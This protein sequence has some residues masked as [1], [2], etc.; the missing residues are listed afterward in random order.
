L[1]EILALS[2]VKDRRVRRRVRSGFASVRLA[3][4]AWAGERV[5][6]LREW[7]ATAAGTDTLVFTVFALVSFGVF[8]WGGAPILDSPTTIDPWLYTALFVN[9]GWT[10]STFAGTYYVARLPWVLPGYILH[11]VF[12]AVAAELIL[13]ALFFLAG[14]LFL[15][16]LVRAH[17]GRTPAF[18]ALAALWLSQQYHNA[19]SWDYVDGPSITYMLGSL[20]FLLTPRT[21]RRRVIYLA[22][23]GFFLAADMT[24]NIFNLVFMP[25]I[26]VSYV[27]LH[28]ARPL[29]RM[30]R[31]TLTD[32]GAAG[33]GA[34]ALILLCGLFSTVAGGPF[35]YFMP[36]FRAA[37][38]IHV[39]K[40]PGYGWLRDDLALLAPLLVLVGT[41]L[42]LVI[43][44]RSPRISAAA[45][46]F[47]LASMLALA[48]AA[49]TMA[50]LEFVHGWAVLEVPYYYDLLVPF[51]YVAV[52]SGVFL[53]LRGRPQ[54][55]LV[56]ALVLGLG[57][58]LL[59]LLLIEIPNAADRVGRAGD[60]PALTVTLAGLA[61][62][63]L[64]AVLRARGV[65]RHLLAL[66]AVAAFAF[67]PN[68]AADADLAVYGNSS[69]HPYE[70]DVFRIGMDL[71]SYL[72]SSGLQAAGRKPWFWYD[73]RSAP[74]LVG[75][76]SLYFYGYTFIGTKLPTIDSDFRFRMS[77]RRPTQLVLLCGEPDCEH[78]AKALVT[79]GIGARSHSLRLLRSGS[80]RIWVRV[81]DL[82]LPGTTTQGVAQPAQPQLRVGDSVEVTG[83]PI[84][85]VTTRQSGMPTIDCFLAAPG[86][87]V[88]GST[89]FSISSSGTVEVH[90][91]G[92][93]ERR[94]E[95]FRR[96]LQGLG[97]QGPKCSRP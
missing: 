56:P 80:L 8:R 87:P 79:H 81:Y 2:G 6:R 72:R 66:A 52:G 59:P 60:I 43:L 78:A 21:G 30:V 68:Y 65:I 5:H 57:A 70:Y 50:L 76:Q 89:G 46:R 18:V 22:L 31:P 61:A 49:A 44:W 16:L 83:A 35:F 32:V 24:T 67:A 86:G 58:A 84:R 85:C 19:F 92:L 73:A 36:Q 82:L 28:V 63:L 95:V 7:A 25:A 64:C 62:I 14:G 77:V 13:H 23:G 40:A 9:F 15:F 75:I 55:L 53:A 26:L 42:L 54:R 97:S 3:A 47:A 27:V 12:P 39:N 37:G 20:Y 4:P 10:Y 33:V 93:G 90:R 48:V 34:G 38:K 69:R 17:L 41:V 1:Q 88:V 51:T 94:T 29:S 74:Y 45:R 96:T 11:A 71:I 91:F